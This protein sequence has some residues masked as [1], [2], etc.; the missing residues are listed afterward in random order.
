VVSDLLMV[1]ERE[2]GEWL[3]RVWVCESMPDRESEVRVIGT[4]SREKVRRHSVNNGKAN[5][6]KY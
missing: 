2:M 3:A 4:R 5:K 6:T 1:D